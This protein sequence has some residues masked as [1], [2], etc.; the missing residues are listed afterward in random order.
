MRQ[1]NKI[2]NVNKKSHSGI[3]LTDGKK[4][5]SNNVT[6]TCNKEANEDK[7]LKCI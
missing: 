1:Q 3:T 4:L 2:G 7:K 5:V 6:I